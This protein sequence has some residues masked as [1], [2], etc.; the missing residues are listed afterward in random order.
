[1]LNRQYINFYQELGLGQDESTE[2]LHRKANVSG[3]NVPH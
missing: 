1:M 3:G 2:E